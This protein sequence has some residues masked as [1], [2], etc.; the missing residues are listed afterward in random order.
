MKVALPCKLL[1]LP[2]VH[3]A[4]TAYT[5]SDLTI[6]STVLYCFIG[7]VAKW[8]ETGERDTSYSWTDVT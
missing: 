7:S 4:Y 5:D 8:G 1:T 3:T 2:S 6:L